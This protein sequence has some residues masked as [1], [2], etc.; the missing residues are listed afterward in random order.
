ML[1]QLLGAPP[2]A[3]APTSYAEP[4][5][6]ADGPSAPS[7]AGGPAKSTSPTPRPGRAAPAAPA[8][9]S[10][11][12]RVLD[13]AG[14]PIANGFVYVSDVSAL[15]KGQTFSIKQQNKAFVPAVA[16]IQRGT[17]V[18]FPNMDAVFHDVFSRSPGNTF[19]VGAI[20]AGE[21]VKSVTLVKAGVVE[22]FC[23]FHAKMN[24]QILVVPGPLFAP[25]DD[26]G[27]FRI[28][29]VPAGRH[30]VAAWAA[31]STPS[32]A[33]VEVNADTAPVELT[34]AS[35]GSVKTHM[36]KNGQA[37]GSYGD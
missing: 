4:Q 15:A 29:G 33:V 36:N 19:D 1:L 26:Q 37:Y 32:N 25:T 8:T 18:S 27:H 20:Q 30:T 34:V 31:S 13:S 2:K 3:A 24:A 14:A 12:G 28:D 23:N 6:S 21:K 9:F 10:L 11:T 5:S 17:Q 22:I 7:G 16:A 35:D